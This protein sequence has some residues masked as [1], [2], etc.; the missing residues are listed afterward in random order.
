MSNFQF[1]HWRRGEGGQE[2][3]KGGFVVCE[4]EI[5]IVL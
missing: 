5:E 1:F 2:G 4:R 3:R